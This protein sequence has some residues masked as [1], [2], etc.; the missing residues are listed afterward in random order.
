M[1]HKTPFESMT[2]IQRSLH[3]L[4]HVIDDDIIATYKLSIS[5]AIDE[6]SELR[7]QNGELLSYIKIKVD[8]F[9]GRLWKARLHP[10]ESGQY[11]N[12]DDGDDDDNKY[13]L[14]HITWVKFVRLFPSIRHLEQLLEGDE[15][16]DDFT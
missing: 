5:N 1:S 3:N 14:M 15:F 12:N 16:V 9:A 11:I 10:G 2:P 13:E 6:L 8:K 7:Q 4:T